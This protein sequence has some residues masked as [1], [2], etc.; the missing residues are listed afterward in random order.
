MALN[1]DETVSVDL[2]REEAAVLCIAISGATIPPSLQ[3]IASRLC[4]KL[5]RDVAP[6]GVIVRTLHRYDAPPP[7]PITKATA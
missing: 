6:I 1:L 5:Q 7:L 4:S 3:I 2:T